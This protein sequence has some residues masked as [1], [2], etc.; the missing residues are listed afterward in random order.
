MRDLLLIGVVGFCCLGALVRPVF[1]MLCFVFFGL[2]NPSSFT[3]GVGRTLPSAYLIAMCTMLGYAVRFQPKRLPIRRENVILLCL[4]GLFFLTTYHA[5]EPED[6]A[7]ALKSV[8][9]V[10]LMVFLSMSMLCTADRL[11]WLMRTIAVGLGLH[12]LRGGFFF[13]TS[14]GQYIVYG[15]EDSFLEGNNSFG[16]ALAMNVPLL[17]Y[18]SQTE[19]SRWF[20]WL[21]R[22]MAVFSIPATLGTYSR[23]A[24]LGLAA[25]ICLIVLRSKRRVLLLALAPAACLAVI[26]FLPERVQTRYEALVEYKEESSAQSRLW[27]WEFAVR[28]GLA[29]PY[30]GAGFDYYSIEAYAM[31]YPEFLARWPGKV[32]SCHS[33][34]LTMFSEH[35]I[36]G[37]SLWILLLASCALSLRRMRAAARS[38]PEHAWVLPYTFMLEG[39]FLAFVVSGTFFDAAYFDMFYQLVAVIVLMKEILAAGGPGLEHGER[40]GAEG[41]V[42]DSPAGGGGEDPGEGPGLGA[43][44]PP[45]RVMVPMGSA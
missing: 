3:W 23:G 4:W 8:S 18:L 15:P 41:P 13:L 1:G 45:E 19:S 28:V 37:I 27:N 38:S 40:R 39:A 10:L 22:I 9:K 14:G 25:A 24:W 29:N 42:R 20:R 17:Y 30:L 32:W 36:P 26:P 44:R 11:K 33:I 12:A 16:L 2:L 21:L 7:F 31:Y 6:A 34:W 43:A 35:G 5:M